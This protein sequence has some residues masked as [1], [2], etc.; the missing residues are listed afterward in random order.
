MRIYAACPLSPDGR[1]RKGCVLVMRDIEREGEMSYKPKALGKFEEDCDAAC[2][3]ELTW[4]E[5]QR[6]QQIESLSSSRCVRVV[7]RLWFAHAFPLFSANTNALQQ[8]SANAYGKSPLTTC[9]PSCGSR[10]FRAIPSLEHRL[11]EHGSLLGSVV[12]SG[13]SERCSEEGQQI[14]QKRANVNTVQK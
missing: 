13:L 6:T 14:L 10:R 8:L 12:W 1:I 3:L 7:I 9:G 4:T 2:R 11:V 5:A